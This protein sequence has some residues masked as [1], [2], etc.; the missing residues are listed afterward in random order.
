MNNIWKDEFEKSGVSE[1]YA[2]IYKEAFNKGIENAPIYIIT[3]DSHKIDDLES[4]WKIYYA[5]TNYIEA[6]NK[7]NDR[8]DFCSDHIAD[9]EWYYCYY[10]IEQIGTLT[11]VLKSVCNE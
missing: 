2:H 1:I 4:H 9:E 11:K 10:L 3:S 5:S 6:L 7:F 8:Y